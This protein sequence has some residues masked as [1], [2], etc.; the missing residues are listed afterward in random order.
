M[1]RNRGIILRII[2]VKFV[3]IF[4]GITL[5]V[6][7]AC[8][9]NNPFPSSTPGVGKRFAC[10]YTIEGDGG[11]ATVRF[12]VNDDRTKPDNASVSPPFR[13]KNIYQC[14]AASMMTLDVSIQDGKKHRLQCKL[15]RRGEQV[16]EDHAGTFLNM[17]AVNPHVHCRYPR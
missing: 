3:V 9:G 11:L 12:D 5:F 8:T 16:R 6:S 14:T 10:G 15:W 7:A 1:R 13:Q 2:R 17:T 4:A